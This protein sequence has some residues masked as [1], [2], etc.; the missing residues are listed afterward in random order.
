MSSTA[1]EYP[2]PITVL[3][4]LDDA[5]VLLLTFN[6]PD[7]NGWTIELEEELPRCWRQVNPAVRVIVRPAGRSSARPTTWRWR[8]RPRGADGL[9]PALSAHAAWSIPKTIIITVSAAAG[10][11]S[12]RWRAPTCACVVHGLHNCVP[13]AWPAQENALSVLP[14]RS[15][16]PARW[17]WLSPRWSRPTGIAARSAE[18]GVAPEELPRR[19]PTPRFALNCSPFVVVDQ[20][21]VHADLGAAWR[22]ARMNPGTVS[23]HAHADFQEGVTSFTE[24]RMIRRLRE[25]PRSTAAG[26]AELARPPMLLTP[27]LLEYRD[28]V[29][30]SHRP[31]SIVVTEAVA[32]TSASAALYP[33][34]TVQV[35]A[36]ILRLGTPAQVE[37]WMPQMVRGGTGRAGVHRTPDRQRPEAT[38]DDR[39]RRR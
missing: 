19:W 33:G 25:T 4:Q 23:G 26:T 21:Q 24:R 16:S 31:R 8:I 9:H 22:E 28:M 39:H 36:T 2:E 27:E 17:T 20:A 3:R 11:G 35:A 38:A 13:A 34:T 15:V 30:A 18:Q 1:Y 6:R 12:S 10:S 32:R 29:V 14:R 5:G 37:R 7:R